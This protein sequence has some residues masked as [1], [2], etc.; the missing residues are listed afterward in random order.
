[1]NLG[2]SGGRFTATDTTL[3]LLLF[4]AYELPESR[5]LGLP[6]WGDAE[7]FDVEAVA[8]GD[9]TVAQ[10]RLMLQSLLAD[11]FKLA[12]HHETRQLPVYAL[13]VAKPGKV[14]PQL[15]AAAK[16]EAPAGSSP[17]TGAA[18]PPPND[19]RTISLTG[20]ADTVTFTVR[21]STIEEFIPGL[22]G[23]GSNRNV[24]KYGVNQYADRPIVDQTGL[25]GMFDLTLTFA[26]SQQP[27]SDTI[28]AGTAAPASLFTALQEQLGL[29]LESTKAPVDV[30]VIDHV[31]EPSPN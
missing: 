27:G 21:S 26:R 2:Q 14:G 3:G 29:K 4:A 13:V 9:P 23:F 6:G 28:S 16:C 8:D 25:T 12:T 7:H 19:C 31:E 20:T 17:Q 30:L 11:R 10:K 5:I 15:H 1:M 18:T 22:V 24:D